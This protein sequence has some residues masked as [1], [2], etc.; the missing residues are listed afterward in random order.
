MI[1][2]MIPSSTH[3]PQ[4]HPETSPSPQQKKHRFSSGERDRETP[5]QHLQKGK[6]RRKNPTRLKL[7]NV[8]RAE[9]WII[10]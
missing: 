6:A 3:S 9:K 7:K 1:P 2:S 10:I 4:P 8:V 5:G